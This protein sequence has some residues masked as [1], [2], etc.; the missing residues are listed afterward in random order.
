MNARLS[1]IALLTGALEKRSGDYMQG[2]TTKYTLNP[3]ILEGSYREASRH[4]N[5]RRQTMAEVLAF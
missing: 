2:F 5:H 1:N 4:L 3:K